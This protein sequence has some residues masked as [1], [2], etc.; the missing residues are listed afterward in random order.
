MDY[1]STFADLLKRDGSVT[2]HQHN[3]QSV[4][5]EMFKVK[6]NL[7]P[8]IMKSLFRFNTNQKLKKAFFGPNVKTEYRG[9]QSLRYFGPIVWDYMLPK[10]LKAITS[11][12]KFKTEV[13]KWVP[14]NCPCRLCKTY[15]S[16]I[17]F[18]NV[19]IE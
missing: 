4:A 12:E 15:I 13:K 19:V 11:I 7:C 6:N 10:D 16:Q 3:I 2:I 17:G 5:I 14:E 18:I 8:E 9:K 1:S